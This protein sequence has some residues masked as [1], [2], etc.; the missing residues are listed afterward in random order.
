MTY[1][2]IKI[3]KIIRKYKY[4]GLILKKCKMTDYRELQDCFEPL[5]LDWS[6]S[7]MDDYTIV[8]LTNPLIEEL[9][10]RR[11]TVIDHWFTRSIAIIAL[12]ISILALLS[13]IGILKLPQYDTIIT[14]ITQK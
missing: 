12:I 8:T 5:D 10:R 3:G 4:L 13:E 2:Q 11:E 9:E 1:Y 6:D 7:N 14:V